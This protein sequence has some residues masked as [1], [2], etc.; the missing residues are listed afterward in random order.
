MTDGVPRH[1]VSADFGE[2]RC[3]CS[4][5]RQRYHRLR[6]VDD[7]DV[8]AHS[9]LFVCKLHAEFTPYLT[10]I[11]TARLMGEGEAE[12]ACVGALLRTT[13]NLQRRDG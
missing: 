3:P 4:N 9:V 6:T 13:G 10:G 2:G 12:R 11:L 5:V 7:D 1:C 8:Q